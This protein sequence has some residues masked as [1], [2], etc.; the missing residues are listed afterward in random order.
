MKFNSRSTPIPVMMAVGLM[1]LSGIASAAPVAPPRI[2]QRYV[3]RWSPAA[4][5]RIRLD[6]AYEANSARIRVARGQDWTRWHAG[7][8][9]TITKGETI[10]HLPLHMFPAGDHACQFDLRT[11][12]GAIF[13]PSEVRVPIVARYTPVSLAGRD[14]K[15]EDWPHQRYPD[16]PQSRAVMQLAWDMEHLYVMPNVPWMKRIILDLMPDTPVER[17]HNTQVPVGARWM[18]LPWSEME[19]AG[20]QI[21][22]VLRVTWTDGQGRAYNAD[23]LLAG[24]GIDMHFGAYIVAAPPGQDDQ[25]PDPYMLRAQYDKVGF[26]L[27]ASAIHWG[28]IE[29]DPPAKVE[30]EFDLSPVRHMPNLHYPGMCYLAIT[31]EGDWQEK[32]YDQD[33]E[34]FYTLARPF[35]DALTQELNRIGVRY[36]SCG[37]NEPGLFHFSD[38]VGRYVRDLNETVHFVRKNMPDAQVIAGKFCG[39]NPETIRTFAAGGFGDN[40]DI[41]DIHPY[42][43]DPRTGCHMG[44]V[45][46]SHEALAELGMGDKRI[47]LGEGWGPTRY[48]PGIDRARHDA[49]V[50]EREADLQRQFYWNGYRCLITPRPDYNPGWVLAAKYFTFNDNV[51]GTYWR[52][53]A[54]PHYNAAGEIDY[55]LLSHLRFGSPEDMKAFF[56]NGGLI[57]FQGQPKGDWLYD[58]PPSLPDVRVAVEHEIPFALRSEAYPIT[59]HITNAES[60]PIRRL[61]LGLRERTALFRNQ[62]GVVAGDARGSTRRGVLEPGQTWSTRLTARVVSGRTGPLRLAVE[63]DYHW[64]EAQYTS[65]AIIRTEVRDDI[66]IVTDSSIWTLDPETGAHDTTVTLR[67]NQRR[68]LMGKLFDSAPLGMLVEGDALE[69]RLATG[70]ER[71]MAIRLQGERLPSGIYMLPSRWDERA[72]VTVVQPQTCPRLK[73]RIQ[74]DGSLSD[75]P[76]R[77]ARDGALQF[78]NA[79][80][81]PVNTPSDPF[82]VPTPTGESVLDRATRSGSESE[83]EDAD[84][85]AATFAARAGILWDDEHLYFGAI[86]EDDRHVQSQEGPDVW[87]G[88]SIQLAFDPL[89]DGGGH[90][91]ATYDEYRHSRN[92]EGHG[93]DGYELA[94]ALSP[95]GPGIAYVRGPEVASPEALAQASIKVIHDGRFTHYEVAIPWT[96]LQPITPETGS[97]FRMS[98]LVNN[99]DGQSRRTLEWGGGI[100]SGKYPSRYVPVILR[101]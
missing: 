94:M 46:A 17:L 89:D 26:D 93:A 101:D 12:T 96:A 72:G 86:V 98:V 61:H 42:S 10:V 21:G 85:R 29:P 73:G 82:P 74:I 23:V 88:D 31:L 58:F 100:G 53:K 24:S 27:R 62:D 92:Q 8:V 69:K 97:R 66:D 76:E 9:R 83:R 64:R 84:D 54:R 57:N 25:G 87:R 75:W 78:K 67:N 51:G 20:P 63:V 6:E 79:G 34:R 77:Q 33:P 99:S 14:A 36:V 7:S 38:R 40:F 70:E 3:T 37:W 60:E 65:D 90:D 55:Y 59:V 81:L 39:G 13:I 19:G 52:V 71:D 56:C 32:L 2:E 50:S 47:Y 28:S 41:L 30:R 35:L 80:A 48:T 68:P 91:A 1:L 4:E 5:A 95:D 49:P 45:V 16:A 44:E 43:N 18:T 11:P 22:Q 15:L